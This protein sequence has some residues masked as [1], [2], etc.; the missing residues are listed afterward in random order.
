MQ[1]NDVCDH[2]AQKDQGHSN[3]MESKESVQGGVTHHIVTT[4]EQSQ[5][6]SDERDGREQIH[7][8]LCTPVGHLSPRQQ[9]TH[10][11]FAHQGQKDGA[12][13]QPNQFTWFSE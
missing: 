5:I 3:H 1:S 12:T 2:Q 4:D 9:I 7:N 11:S 10:E 6:G 13:K 8:H